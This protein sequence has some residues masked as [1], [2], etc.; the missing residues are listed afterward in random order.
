MSTA[1][2]AFLEDA[3]ALVNQ[4]EHAALDDLG[5]LDL[6]PRHACLLP[7][8]GDDLRARRIRQRLAAARLVAIVTGERLLAEASALEQAFSYA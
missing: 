4:S 8:L 7:A 5:I 3:S 2:S 6:P 1:R